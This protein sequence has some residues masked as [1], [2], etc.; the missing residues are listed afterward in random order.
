MFSDVWFCFYAMKSI[1]S[2]VLSTHFSIFTPNPG[3][4]EAIWRLHIFFKW[5]DWNHQLDSLDGGNFDRFLH[6]ATWV[7][8]GHHFP[9]KFGLVGLSVVTLDLY[10]QLRKGGCCWVVFLGYCNEQGGCC[11]RCKAA[12]D[13]LQSHRIFWHMLVQGIVKSPRF[14]WIVNM[15]RNPWNAII[16]GV[17]TFWGYLKIWKYS[18]TRSI[19]NPILN[20]SPFWLVYW[21]F[22]RETQHTKVSSSISPYVAIL[23]LR[24]ILWLSK[25]VAIWWRSSRMLG[26]PSQLV[27]G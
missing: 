19:A 7:L 18:S 5:V 25:G 13:F 12:R 6:S 17:W 1:T 11:D 4:N 16:W 24:R 22:E 27:S 26:G 3:E 8:A 2:W 21:G 14:V 10:V 9:K 23:W 20:I 15:K